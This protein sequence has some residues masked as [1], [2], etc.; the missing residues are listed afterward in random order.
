MLRMALYGVI[1]F[2][3]VLVFGMFISFFVLPFRAD[4]SV[5]LPLCV[6]IVNFMLA[7]IHCP[8]TDL[9]NVLRGRLGMPKI[10]GFIGY[11][12]LGKG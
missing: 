10:K 2:H 1:L 12:I 11:Y 6:I 4:W 8:L 3:F 7:R 5:A 9:E